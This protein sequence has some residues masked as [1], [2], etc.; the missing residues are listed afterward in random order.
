MLDQQLQTCL[1]T[2]NFFAGLLDVTQRRGKQALRWEQQANS[3]TY[4]GGTAMGK[5][6]ISKMFPALAQQTA[7]SSAGGTLP[8]GPD[9]LALIK[10]IKTT[11]MTTPTNPSSST[12]DEN[13]DKSKGISR[14]ELNITL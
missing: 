1:R 10:T 5:I 8:Q 3:S 14:S 12:E 6:K 4:H 7:S 2:F 13:Q 11:T 9:I